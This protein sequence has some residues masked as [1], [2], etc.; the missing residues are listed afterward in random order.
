MK[1]AFVYDVIYP[2]VKGGG[3]RRYYELARRL[4]LRHEVHLFGMKFWEGDDMI[5]NDDGV[6]LHGVCSPKKLYVDGRRSIYQAIYYSVKLVVPLLKQDFD[7]VDCSSVPFFPVFVCELY[8]IFRRKPL[9]VTWHEYWSDY[10][11]I[12]LA[13]KWKG[14]IAKTIE[15]VSSRLPDKI[16]AVSEHTK[17]DLVSHKVPGDKVQVIHNGVDFDEIQISP[18]ANN[19]SDVIFAGRLIKDKNVDVLMRIIHI[20]KESLPR[21]KCYIIGDGPERKNLEKLRV[22]LGLEVNV[23]LLGFLDEHQDVYGLMKAS[24]VFVLPSEREGFGMVVLEAN[25]C[26]LPVVVVK[27]KH[28]AASSLVKNGE[29]GFACDLDVQEIADTVYKLLTNDGMR[30]RMQRAA[31]A[32]AQQFDWDVITKH[33]EQIYQQLIV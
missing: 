5:Q 1:I 15:W 33:T 24:K 9:I 3:E 28:S 16:I 17:A 8:A 23:E 13:S 19:A 22:E 12:Y 10:W 7:L 20:L 14:L 30:T 26:G 31:V 25:A 6:F 18:V 2:Y 32:W 11:Y 27:A 21:I 29:S 4:G